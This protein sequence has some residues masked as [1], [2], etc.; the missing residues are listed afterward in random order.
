M[1]TQIE[2]MKGWMD[3]SQAQEEVRS[4][5]A[6]EMRQLTLTKLSSIYTEDIEA[7][8][9]TF[10]RMMEVFKVKKDLWTFKLAP[11]LT[12]KAQ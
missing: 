5:R 10:E 7:Y 9:T 8:L 6:E 12:R 2:M 11:Q 1:Q 4:K 3:H